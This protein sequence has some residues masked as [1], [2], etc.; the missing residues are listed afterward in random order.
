MLRGLSTIAAFGVC[1]LLT[2]VPVPLPVELPL[3]VPALG[4]QAVLGLLVAVEAVLGLLV[5]EVAV[6]PAQGE[7]VLGLVVVE[8]A[9]APA[10]GEAVLGLLVVVVAV[11]PAQG[12]AQQAALGPLLPELLASVRQVKRRRPHLC[13]PRRPLA[14]RPSPFQR[15]DALPRPRVH[16]PAPCW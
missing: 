13:L 4:L 10:Q 3:A 1:A 7:A 9:V 15:C 11:A 16:H 6:A 8:V 14:Q 5:V 2:P 12:E